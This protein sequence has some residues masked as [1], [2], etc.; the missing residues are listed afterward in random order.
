LAHVVNIVDPDV[1]V[2]G[3]G[4]SQLPHLN[5]QLP[6]LMGPHIFADRAS[7]V[8]KA[9]RWGDA[10]VVGAP[11]ACGICQSANDQLVSD[12]A[13]DFSWPIVN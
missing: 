7:V 4:L 3:G 1:L 8:V 12:H 5:E 13:E 11:P 6:Q 9:R 10:A 2:I